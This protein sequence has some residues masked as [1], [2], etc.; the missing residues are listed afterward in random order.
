MNV[1]ILYCSCY[2]YRTLWSPFFQLKER[3]FNDPSIPVYLGTDGSEEGVRACLPP[4]VTLLRYPEPANN[5]TNY[6]TRVRWYLRSIPSK[7]VVF[8]YD[9]MFLSAPVDRDA[10]AKACALMNTDHRVK[11]IKLSL[12]S[13]PF[14]GETYST[15]LGTFQRS[16]STD[17]YVLNVQPAVFDREFLLSVLDEVDRVAVKNGPSDFETHG[18]SVAGRLPYLYLR[19]TSDILPILNDG[20]VVRS[21]IVY[22]EARAFLD[23]EGIAIQTYGQN[24]IYDL[25]DPSNTNTL[26]PQLKLELREWFRITV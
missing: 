1:S 23:R 15:P 25:S 21:G 8:W 18:T 6:I 5:N 26:N 14:T 4:G 13:Y 24:C 20:G 3:Y 22:P 2:M 16:S 9:D 7:Y 11:L 10:F 17:P 19:S 12:H